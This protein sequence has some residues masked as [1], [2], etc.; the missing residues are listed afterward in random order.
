MARAS[1]GDAS[2]R[3]ATTNTKGGATNSGKIKSN[4]ERGVSTI[5]KRGGHSNSGRG[6]NTESCGGESNSL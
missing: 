5:T 1:P 2:H 3:G 6:V 4:S